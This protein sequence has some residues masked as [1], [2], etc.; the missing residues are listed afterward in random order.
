M[1][2]TTSNITIHDGPYGL[3]RI[4]RGCNVYVNDNGI[5]S[6]DGKRI[7]TAEAKRALGLADQWPTGVKASDFVD[8]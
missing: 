2:A 3:I 6:A 7:S 1:A 8:D 4:A 5:F